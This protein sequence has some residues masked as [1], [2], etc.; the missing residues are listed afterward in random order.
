MANF[1]M[2]DYI[3]AATAD[4]D[5]TLVLE[6]QSEIREHGKKNQIVHVGLDGSEERIS[7][8]TQSVFEVIYQYKALTESDSG[9]IFDLYHDSAK[10]N[11]IVRT[12]KWT[13]GDGHDYVVRFDCDLERIKDRARIWGFAEIK[14]KVTGK[15]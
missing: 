15:V 6:A 10:A 3:S 1:E 5:Y 4:Y 2:Y 14:L 9:T 13:R 12:F 8:S 7:L 11:G